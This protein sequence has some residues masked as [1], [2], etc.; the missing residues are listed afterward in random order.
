MTYKVFFVDDEASMRAGI[1]NSVDWENSDFILAGEAPDGE[2]ALSLMEEIK[3]DI[4]VTDVR[5][6]FMDGLELSKKAKL[7]MPH[8]KIIILSGHDEF[9]YAKQA[10]AIGVEDY[11]LK[12]ITSAMLMETLNLVAARL[13]E[14]KKEIKHVEDMKEGERASK[15]EGLISDLL[16]GGIDLDLAPILAEEL[17]CPI[18]AEHYLVMYIEFHRYSHSIPEVYY[19]A[20][21]SALSILEGSENILLLWQGADRLIC[22]LMDQEE[23]QLE[24]KAYSLAREVKNKVEE[25]E[26]CLVSIALGTVVSH[27]K[28]WPKSLTDADISRQ[29]MNLT[30]RNQIISMQDIRTD[31]LMPFSALHKLPA[32]DKL[33]Y[34]SHGDIPQLVAAHFEGSSSGSFVY[35][36]Y[37]LMDVLMSASKI[38]EE[39]GGNGNEVLAE[40]SDVSKLLQASYGAEKMKTLLTGIFEKVITFRDNAA[41]GAYRDIISK[42]QKYIQ[43]N[44]LDKDISI[45]LV[46]REVGLS[47]NYFSTIFSQ[48]TGETFI[49]YLTNLRIEHAKLLLKTTSMR[50]IDISH[51]IGYNDTQYFSYVF[52]KK[53]GMTPK[54]FRSK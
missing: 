31:S 48:E 50:T 17:G 20:R 32:A 16:Y 54:E 42:A 34:A 18:M 47:P 38:I 26:Q 44:F 30:K 15:V 53:V 1:R 9:E 46:A 2:I 11:L 25:S 12:P 21:E 45:H 29:Y 10:I 33:R 7:A 28:D 49:S 36:N 40:Y 6:P 5:M 41:G 51:E 14:E 39:L 22:V 23:K 35:M 8:L 43:D 13:T 37:I 3:P 27:I 52:K 24:K 4:L 19:D